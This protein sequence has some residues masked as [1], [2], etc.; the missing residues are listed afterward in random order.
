M[1]RKLVL[2]TLLMFVAIRGATG[3]CSA[4]ILF[5]VDET[6]SISSSWFDLAKQ[7]MRDFLHCFADPDDALVFELLS[8]SMP[9]RTSDVRFF[10]S[11]IRPIYSFDG[12]LKEEGLS[13]IGLAIRY[14]QVAT[15]DDYEAEAAMARAAEIVLYAVIVGDF[16][17]S[18]ALDSIV[19]G[20]DG[21][22]NSN[23]PCNL[24]DRILADLCNITGCP[25]DS[26]MVYCFADPCTVTACPATP[27]ATCVSDY[28]GGCN[29]NFF[30]TDGGQACCGGQGQP[31]ET[32]LP[33]PRP[34]L[35]MC[36]GGLLC[37]PNTGNFA[38]GTCQTQDWVDANG[39][40]PDIRG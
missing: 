23:N 36:Q 25:V 22:F 31:C 40:M 35:C 15:M 18:A 11:A 26:P 10:D 8:Y 32:G 17:D 20:S 33:I 28:C 14:M 4:D 9:L 7:F 13:P 19:G 21:V 16:V 3:Q 37:F 6:S 30:D 38:I 27:D 12:L 2:P 5:V 34:G 1:L 39:G 24:A 29:A